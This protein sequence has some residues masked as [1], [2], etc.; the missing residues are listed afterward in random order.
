MYARSGVQNMIIVSSGLDE[1]ARW[2]ESM[3]RAFVRE[4]K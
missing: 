1:L 4:R 3:V 2:I